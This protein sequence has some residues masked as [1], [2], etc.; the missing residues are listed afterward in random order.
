MINSAD[1]DQLASSE[2]NWSGSTLFA[3]AGHIQVLQDQGE[4]QHYIKVRG[5][6]LQP[7]HK[8]LMTAA[9]SSHL[10]LINL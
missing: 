9:S 3:K 6:S 8:H 1:P 2:A 5:H 4:Y 7:Q 10:K